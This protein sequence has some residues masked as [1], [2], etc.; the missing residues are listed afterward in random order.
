MPKKGENIYKRKDGRWEGRYIKGRKPDGKAIYG[1]VYA[2]TYRDVKEALKKAHSITLVTKYTTENQ[3]HD[4]LLKDIAEDWLKATIPQIKE[5]T[6]VKYQNILK[7][8]I[9]P[10]L[11]EMPIYC[12]TYT[13]LEAF[14]NILLS[15]GGI[16]KK[17]LS[18][19]T[20]ADIMTVLRSILRFAAKN[21]SLV[22]CDGSSIKIKK[23]MKEMRIFTRTEQEILY[24]YLLSN[25]NAPNMGILV[26]MFTGLRVGEIC[27]LH[28]EDISIH[29]QTIHVH[30]T[31]Q[32]LQVKEGFSK[33][34]VMIT[35][36]K[37]S[38]SVR[39]IPVPENIMKIITK[40]QTSSTGYFLTGCNDHFIEP[41]TM[42]NRFKHVLSV[43]GIQNAN[44]HVLRHTFAT[45][46][47]ELGF[48]IKTL[49][50]ILGHASVNITM[51][52]YVHPTMELKRENMKRL[53]AF[54]AVNENRQDAE[55]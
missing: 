5:S 14:S 36:P 50:E 39:T 12:L 11:G 23:K 53:S 13:H 1:Y 40:Y 24:A 37:S 38:C 35:T 32:R 16:K 15:K 8:Y 31:M 41:R 20:V 44:Y 29:E 4:S 49:S 2:K 43:C 26:C 34:R 33:T 6:A 42:Q 48:D 21:G 25:L 10:E 52:R 19:K 51:N 9:I 22:P 28:W 27:A 30:Q 18:A 47:V 17:G 45:R 54:I 3:Y 55:E 46:C 7:N